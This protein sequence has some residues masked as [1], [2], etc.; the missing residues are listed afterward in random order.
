MTKPKPIVAIV[1][2]DTRMLESLVD[3]LES[4]GYTARGYVSA[5]A[6]M[7]VGL[8]ELDALVTDI[9]MR[10]TDGTTLCDLARQRRPELPVFL[11]TS[12]HDV[13]DDDR[14]HDASGLFHKPFNATALLEAIAKALSRGNTGG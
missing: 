7:A 10:T 8:D 12:R 5:A 2:S 9:G 13:T 3:L 4:G 14:V 1:D 6:L 11:I